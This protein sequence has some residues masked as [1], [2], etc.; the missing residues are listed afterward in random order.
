MTS[1][2]EVIF[3]LLFMSRYAWI[4][5]KSFYS[6]KAKGYIV[7]DPTELATE[8]ALTKDFEYISQ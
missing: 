3:N 7:K 1:L 2:W 5:P 8:I 6:P 4:I